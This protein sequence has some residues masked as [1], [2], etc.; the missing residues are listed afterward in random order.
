VSARYNASSPAGRAGRIAVTRRLLALGLALAAGLAVLGPGGGRPGR[1]AAETA[2]I[3]GLAPGEIEDLR[4]GRGMA[5]ARAADVNGYPGPRHVLDAADAGQLA[6][7]PA[8]RAAVEGLFAAMAAETR[9]LGARILAEEQAL[10]AALR[11]GRLDEAGLGAQVARIGALRA[12]LR[13]VHL[14]THLRTRAVL[15]DHQVAR[16]QALRGHA[17]GGAGPHRH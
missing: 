5:L 9:A 16:Y 6:L 7:A 8:Q 3:R 11:D 15:T 4:E 10:E 14:R 1:A 2:G 12:E 17:A 13:T